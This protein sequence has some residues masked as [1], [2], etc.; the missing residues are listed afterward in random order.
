MLPFAV[1]LAG[2]ACSFLAAVVCHGLQNW[3]SRP[4]VWTLPAPSKELW[5]QDP[6]NR[7]AWLQE[8]CA[9]PWV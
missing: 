7:Q 1:R 9:V 2:I 5:P 3:S 6:M 4:N 8:P